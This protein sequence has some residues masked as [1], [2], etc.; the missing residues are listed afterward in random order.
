MYR[1]SN[2]LVADRYRRLSVIYQPHQKIKKGVILSVVEVC[3][4]ASAPPLCCPKFK[5]S[6]DKACSLRLQ[7]L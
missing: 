5:T 7:A 2:Y 1:I 3:G 4:Q 6:D